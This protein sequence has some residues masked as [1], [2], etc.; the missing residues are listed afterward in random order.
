MTKTKEM[1]IKEIKA[2]I[3]GLKK[4]LIKHRKN[5]NSD[6]I[7]TGT[8]HLDRLITRLKQL[9]GDNYKEI[10]LTSIELPVVRNVVKKKKKSK[11][12]SI[13]VI[14]GERSL[15][16]LAEIKS[17]ID[18]IHDE[19]EQLFQ[20]AIRNEEKLCIAKAYKVYEVFREISRRKREFRKMEE[21][22]FYGKHSKSNSYSVKTI[23]G[24]QFLSKVSSKQ[25]N[26]SRYYTHM[27]KIKSNKWYL[28]D[29]KHG[30]EGMNLN[31]GQA[32]MLLKE[33]IRVTNIVNSCEIKTIK[34]D[35]LEEIEDKVFKYE[36]KVPIEIIE[37]K[38]ESIFD[39]L[40][41]Y[42][43]RLFSKQPV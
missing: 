19:I 3:V 5:G 10:D 43:N 2:H 8:E 27:A 24:V 12:K 37:E 13:P 16:K 38:K 40:I 25:L 11:T 20:M 22:V 14:G 28:S 9:E 32:Y 34:Y 35:Y 30:F 18:K 1:V 29:L 31:M 26:G 4:N 6:K 21:D 15:Q 23:D 17:Y 7:R 42:A 41:S 36:K 39:K 33:I